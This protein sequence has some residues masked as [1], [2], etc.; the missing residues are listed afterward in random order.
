MKISKYLQF[1]IFAIVLSLG[2]F[3]VARASEEVKNFEVNIRINS[4]ASINVTESIEYDFGSSKRHGIYRDIPVKYNARGGNYNLRV[5]DISVTDNLGSSYNFTVSNKGDYKSI[6]IGN[7]DELVSGI[8][9]YIVRYRVERAINYFSESDE[10]YWNVTGNEWIVPIKKAS[11]TVYLPEDVFSDSLNA[12]C[13]AGYS[14]SVAPCN[15]IIYADEDEYTD[16]V[17]FLEENLDIGEG[18]TFALAFPKSIVYQPTRSEQFMETIK[19]NLILFFPILIFFAMFF[20]WKNKGKDPK[21]RGTIIT[22]FD[23]PDQL[24]PAEIGTIVDEKCSGKEISAEIINLA[25]KGYLKIERVEKKILFINDVDY[26]FKKLKE[27]T[28][29][30]NKHEEFLLSGIFG[31]KSEVK[32]SEIKKDFY[33]DY[34]LV[35]KRVYE[36]VSQKGYFFHSPQ[37]M[38]LESGI[39]YSFLTLV[40]F[41]IFSS[42]TGTSLGAY[43]IL[44]LCFALL[45]VLVFSVLMPQRTSRGVTVKEHILGLKRYMSVAEKDRMEFH[46]A[47]EKN[48]EQFEKLLPFAIA[49]GVEKKWAEQ[50][51]D[52][53]RNN[54]VWY[55]GSI[56]SDGFN[57]LALIYNLD[58][59][60]SQLNEV[61]THSSASS[62]GSGFSGGGFSG[63][64]FGGGGGGSW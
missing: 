64:G 50:F 60:N 62:G 8:K 17:S 10:L 11:V 37:R 13:F 33:D 28:D 4:D 25:I 36:A 2:N 53:Y 55:T 26:V 51:K 19:D 45:I 41:S 12:L 48:P 58:S 3:S 14:E 35:Q 1:A 49:L 22:E 43:S 47:P 34:Q 30:K 57:S 21:G 59:L 52:I 54:P 38:R 29:L 5:N 20:I 6:Q 40:A 31:D 9:S 61:T 56:G 44:S 32:L 18:L 7:T 23:V 24:T 16:S 46:N 39:K 15:S 42:I 27:G 63:G